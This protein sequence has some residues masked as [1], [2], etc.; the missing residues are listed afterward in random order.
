MVRRGEA[1]FVSLPFLF[2]HLFFCLFRVFYNN[3]FC[4]F[5]LL[6]SPPS[7]CFPFLLP[8]SSGPRHSGHGGTL[9][10]PAATASHPEAAPVLP[11]PGPPEPGSGPGGGRGRGAG[12][13]VFRSPSWGPLVGDSGWGAGSSEGAPRRSGS[14]ERKGRFL[15]LLPS[16]LLLLLLFFKRKFISWR[17]WQWR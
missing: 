16:L 12:M 10:S 6:F 2:F 11:G 9:P 13:G 17:I 14:A 8:G 7:L 5:F 4:L 1:E 3:F 15:L